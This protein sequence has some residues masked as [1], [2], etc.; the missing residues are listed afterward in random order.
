MILFSFIVLPAFPQRDDA[1]RL[2][3]IGKEHMARERYGEAMQSFQKAAKLRDLPAVL[4]FNIYNDLGQ[5]KLATGNYSDALNCFRLAMGNSE[6]D[7]EYTDAV[8]LNL[9]ELYTMTGRYGEA[10][11]QLDSLETDHGSRLGDIHKSRIE[12]FS[13]NY[14]GAIAIL[15]SLISSPVLPKDI[16]AVALQNRGYAYWGL[17]DTHTAAND[18][19]T[20]LA[21]MG[22]DYEY[23]PALANLAMI[24]SEQ[25][26]CDDALKD[27]DKVMA[28]YSSA[29]GKGELSHDHIIALRKYAEIQRN[30]GD[31]SISEN[32]FKKYFRAE[33]SRIINALP[34]MSAKMRLDY[35]N[36]EKPLLSKIFH[37]NPSDAMFVYEVASFRRLVSLL[38]MN[39]LQYLER[40]IHT[41]QAD[42]KKSV[43]K[44]EMLVE[45][46]RYRDRKD[47]PRYGAAMLRDDGK[48]AFVPLFGEKDLVEGNTAAAKAYRNAMQYEN[49]AAINR[50]YRDSTLSDMIWRPIL[51]FAA[52]SVKKSDKK[53][54]YFAP[55]GILNIIGIENL[56]LHEGDAVE[57]RRVSST[58]MSAM[59]DKGS[60]YLT[61]PESKDSSHTIIAGGFNYDISA[62]DAFAPIDDLPEDEVNTLRNISE[63]DAG[64]IIMRSLGID[65]MNGVFAYLP[66][67]RNEA[68][69]VSSIIADGKILNSLSERELKMRLPTTRIMH[70]ATH[71]YSL[72]S[73]I[74][75]RP[76]FLK[77]QFASDE[78]LTAAGLALSGA[79]VGYDR[80]DDNIITGLEIST[81]SL[82]NLDFAVLSACQT[83]KGIVFDEGATGLLR[84]FK[85][86]GAHIV[87]S[88]LWSVDDMSTSAFMKR[89][90][91]MLS[92]NHTIYDSYREA[93]RSVREDKRIVRTKPFS[94][95]AMK[96]ERKTVN[97]ELPP[98]K[99]PYYWAPFILV[100]A[101]D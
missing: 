26:D 4:L 86:A 12:S 17:G 91:H 18:I 20:A 5:C 44:G 31:I 77:D 65:S 42:L 51:D 33:R 39:D 85:N 93:Q 76:E 74:K 52:S 78:S 9:S 57:L 30:C 64:E 70:L 55:D 2:I 96:R 36:Y 94:A 13:N 99:D 15:D 95:S 19:S 60:K 68:D 67:T 29:D 48:Y 82:G 101:W 72:E 6:D 73:G 7:P 66:G 22:K 58:L 92:A 40:L 81:L 53:K 62:P 47:A 8:H 56:P 69:T 83:A 32:A 11:N 45:F 54:I 75:E 79:N 89:F 38:G 90:Y 63:V 1:R 37:D 35:W 80:G 14:V 71:G 27:I 98:Y 46:V 25:N 59:R 97:K 28:Y 23:Y 100:D 87:M 84:A 41:T 43:K 49:K 21:D 10:R 24:R 3:S 88:S 61:L 50:L 16:R 34:E